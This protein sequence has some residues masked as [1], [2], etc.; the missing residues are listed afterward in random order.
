LCVIDIID[1]GPG[2]PEDIHDQV[3]FPMVSSKEEGS[4]LGLAISQ[5]IIRVHGGSID[6]S[7]DHTGAVFSILMPLK[8]EDIQAQSA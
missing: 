8:L 3:F 6:F 7:S 4:G 1:N 2:I 5:D